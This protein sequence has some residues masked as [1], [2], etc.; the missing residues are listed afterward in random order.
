AQFFV[1]AIITRGP[2]FAGRQRSEVQFKFS[3]LPRRSVE[4]VQPFD[5]AEFFK[6]LYVDGA[7]FFLEARQLGQ[8]LVRCEKSLRG[9]RM[10]VLVKR[11]TYAQLP[12]PLTA[13]QDDAPPAY[14]RLPGEAC[15]VC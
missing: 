12:L 11:L 14:K 6:L 13:A 1:V 15:G 9:N 5:N 7:L 4:H 3:P 10:A 2:A 8:L